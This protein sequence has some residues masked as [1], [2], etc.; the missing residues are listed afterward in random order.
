MHT[1]LQWAKFFPDPTNPPPSLPDWPSSKTRA[2]GKHRVHQYKQGACA[3]AAELLK[4]HQHLMWLLYALWMKR[5]QAGSSRS[6][7][8][9]IE[10]PTY[11]Y[12]FDDLQTTTALHSLPAFTHAH[13]TPLTHADGGS[14]HCIPNIIAVRLLLTYRQAWIQ[15]V[16]NNILHMINASRFNRKLASD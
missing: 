5:R 12:S 1:C 3:Q 13:L 6:S 2:D 14:V 11:R 16:K 9:E 8:W 15:T 7:I 10:L 4:K